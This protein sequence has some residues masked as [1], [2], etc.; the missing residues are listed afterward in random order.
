MQYLFRFAPAA[1]LADL[2]PPGALQIRRHLERAP[3]SAA[4]P[5]TLSYTAWKHNPFGVEILEETL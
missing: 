3:K 5:D 4:G 2:P 1:D